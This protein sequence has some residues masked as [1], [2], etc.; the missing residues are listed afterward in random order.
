MNKNS[1]S[2]VI[3]NGSI[4]ESSVARLKMSKYRTRSWSN[5][6]NSAIY[7]DQHLLD[8]I[9]LLLNYRPQL[10]TDLSAAAGTL[11]F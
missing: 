3:Q 2:F 7:L 6:Q 4:A 1:D 8:M 5:T 11:T 10:G 9:T